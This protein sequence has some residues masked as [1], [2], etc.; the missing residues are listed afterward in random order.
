MTT[1]A[2]GSGIARL[3]GRAGG[4][5]MLSR[6][7]GLVREQMVAVL[8][9]AGGAT[10]AY[11]VAF[12]IPN[13]L[14]DLVAENTLSSA[15]T[16]TFKEAVVKDGRERAFALANGVV[17]ALLL[18]LGSITV[19]ALIFTP[20]LVWLVA[21]GMYQTPGKA[22]L[23]VTM[24]RILMPFLL[25]VALAAVAMAMLLSFGYAFLPAIA[26]V[27][28][29]VGM[30]VV[31]GGL[32]LAAPQL[33][34]DPIVGLAIGTLVGGFGQLVVQLPA[35]GREGYRIRPRI[36]FAD[37][38]VREVLQLMAPAILA[39]AALEINVMVNTQI[40]S[41]LR[42][43]SISWLNFAFRLF[44]LPIGVFG[45]SIAMVTLPK[46]KEMLTLGETESARDTVVRALRLVVLV[47]L[48]A[49]V[50]LVVLAR[51]L[52]SL[53][54]EYR[55]FSSFAAD[56][57][58][59]ALTCYA[60]GLV[61]LSAVKVLS[62]IYYALKE[63]WIAV[64]ASLVSIGLN[65]ALSFALM[66]PMGHRGLALA[67]ALNG[68]VNML[69]LL[70]PLP[71]R[72]GLPFRP[73]IAAVGQVGIASVAMG[74]ATWWTAGAVAGALG[75]A[76]V[77]A[78]AAIVGAGMLAGALVLVVCLKLMRFTD[79]DDLLAMLRRKAAPPA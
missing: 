52:V 27:M 13:L 72:L 24:T 14:R 26:P 59:A 4:A 31:G 47:T 54:Y 8:F 15:F 41:W 5:T 73:L 65:I 46:V 75:S 56:E 49:T 10:D 61:A 71:K 12:R 53:I 9:G 6:L 60:V 28:F 18:I 29:N 23:T 76:G 33:G 1:E 69:L 77:L 78:R 68:V 17:G 55:K 32:A 35:L 66:G 25:A 22:E 64:R 58:A 19:L 74:A 62:P 70:L 45:V 43:G 44:Q 37:P 2:R 16:P 42:E 38:G 21:S 48:P 51:P 40:A 30:I 7:T 79:L 20:Q 57:T 67:A 36:D 11:N 50:G 34:I 63:P 39:H 3:A